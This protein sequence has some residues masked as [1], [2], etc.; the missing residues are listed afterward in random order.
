[1]VRYGRRGGFAA[2]GFL[3]LGLMVQLF[4]LL[5]FA[6]PGAFDAALR[7]GLLALGSND[8]STAQQQLESASK[9]QPQ[10][11]DVWLALAQTY[12][13]Q[14][15]RESADAAVAKVESTAPSNPILLHGL[16]IYYAETGLLAKAAEFESRYASNAPADTAAKE[17]AQALYFQAGQ[18][19]LRSQNFD[20]AVKI[21][22]SGLKNFPDSAQLELAHGVALYGLRRFPDAIDSFIRTIRLAPE[23]K[24]PYIFLGRMVDVA[25]GKLPRITDVFA[26]YVK[27]EP[28]EALSHFLY[29][30]AL[31]ASSGD[32]NQ[33]EKLLRT[34]L[35][36]DDNIWES[37]FQMG[38]L[39]ERKHAYEEAA[40]EIER[41]ISLDPREPVP[42]YRLARLYDR[43]G[44][45][46]EAESERATHARLTAQAKAEPT[47][48]GV[49]K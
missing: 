26:A 11:G 2:F 23:V 7:N 36:L 40:K 18:E 9:L 16:S 42:H 49:I 19:Q 39:L 44:R 13:K 25:E 28:R 1:M 10:R 38:L 31:A 45:S 41:S 33:I 15:N 21:L 35:S 48:A 32:V 5:L 37:H 30:K 22:N 17:R 29:A 27:S 3:V 46:A 14:N 34:S 43:L 4:C 6:D 20:S 12:L 47:A 24:Q 8:L